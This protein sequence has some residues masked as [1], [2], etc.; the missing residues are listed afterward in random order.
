MTNA[1]AGTPVAAAKPAVTTAESF[2]T[3]SPLYVL[4]PVNG[5]S[6]PS[7]I[8]F[9]CPGTCGNETTRYKVHAPTP[10]GSRGSAPETPDS[11]IESIAYTCFLCRKQ[12]LTVIYRKVEIQR[13]SDGT[14]T[15]VAVIKIGQYPE[16]AIEIPNGVS[17]NLGQEAAGL[18]RKAL[19]S[20][21]HGFGLAAVSYMRR[22]V[23]DKTNELIE[24]AAKL[25]ESHNIDT[26]VVAAMR[27]AADSK[28]YTTYEDK[29]KFAATVFPDNL[30]VGGANPLNVLYGLVSGGL[31]GLG[32]PECI[33]LAD[34]TRD[35]FEY[36]F[37]KLQAEIDDR[38]A[39]IDKVKKLI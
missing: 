29:L 30:K 5:F 34:E 36:V 28:K 9:E 22:V 8:S 31:H 10:L 7:Q 26:A 12:T 39:F 4:T 21:N 25:A 33:A 13:R 37:E 18:Y 35:V 15:T 38:K 32:E 24:V 27:G 3:K 23:E 19:V 1:D 16:P 11:L 17:K 2:I 6:T 20:R 14:Q